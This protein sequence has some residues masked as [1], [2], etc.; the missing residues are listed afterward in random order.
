MLTQ[1]SATQ[2]SADLDELEQL[3][4]NTFGV[5]EEL[6]TNPAEAHSIPP[7]HKAE[8]VHEAEPDRHEVPA[9]LEEI[10]VEES[11]AKPDVSSYFFHNSCQ[12]S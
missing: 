1:G 3:P 12:L 4:P 2:D 5:T 10:H 8:L 7:E 6:T 11:K 9:P